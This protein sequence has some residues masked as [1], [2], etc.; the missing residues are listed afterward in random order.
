M[1]EVRVRKPKRWVYRLAQIVLFTL[2]KICFGFKSYHSDNFPEDSP[3]GVILAPNH[4]SYLDP[5]ILGIALKKPITFLAKEYLFRPFLL[6]D[7]LGWLGCVPIKSESQDFRSL[8]QLFRVLKEGKSILV[9]PEG[10][11]TSDGEFQKPEPGLGFLAVKSQAW[12]LP[13]YIRGTFAAFPKGAKCFR[14]RPVSVHF[15]R[16]FIPAADPGILS[17]K[18]PYQAVSLRIMDEI[19]KIKEEVDRADQG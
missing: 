19:K 16:P 12:V 5:P 11:R 17:E 15:G 8:R 10:T 14:C 3:R 13:V 18:D 4:A 6:G 9:F 2:Y 7:V 1:G